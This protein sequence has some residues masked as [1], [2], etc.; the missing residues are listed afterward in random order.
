MHYPMNWRSNF[1]LTKGHYSIEKIIIIISS[2]LSKS[3]AIYEKKDAIA[4]VNVA[5]KLSGEMMVFSNL[6]CMAGS[7]ESWNN[8]A[9]KP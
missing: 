7:H 3:L 8:F 5:W 2:I 6:D 9:K 1:E 4:G